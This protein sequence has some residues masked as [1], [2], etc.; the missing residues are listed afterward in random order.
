M[1]TIYHIILLFV[2]I[3]LEAPFYIIIK[4]IE[5][6]NTIKACENGDLELVKHR[7]NQKK[8]LNPE[9]L[10][11]AAIK[12]DHIDIMKFLLEKHV[13]IDYMSTAMST[14]LIFDRKNI[15]QFLIENKV[16]GYEQAIDWI[17]QRNHL[18]IFKIYLEKNNY[19]NPKTLS[20]II[21][22]NRIEM[23]KILL[24][25]K[26]IPSK[27]ILFEACKQ[28]KIKIVE[29][30]YKNSTIK[31]KNYHIAFQIAIENYQYNIVKSLAEIKGCRLQKENIY[32]YGPVAKTI[33]MSRIA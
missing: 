19:V 31:D 13:D 5:D 16:A 3:I 15:I 11:I 18:D 26:T 23:I 14:A 1:F 22:L 33:L 12:A 10:L 20:S 8:C 27:D 2:I 25:K 9:G 29:D 21:K 24:E 4:S 17:V 32:E 7:I 28:G 6:N 30:F